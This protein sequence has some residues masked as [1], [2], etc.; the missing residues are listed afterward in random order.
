M[1]RGRGKSKEE[2]DDDILEIPR[3]TRQKRALALCFFD[4]A[5]GEYDQKLK[6][7]SRR[8]KVPTK[9]IALWVLGGYECIMDLE[10]PR[11][12]VGRPLPPKDLLTWEY[13]DE[14]AEDDAPGLWVPAHDVRDWMLTNIIQEGGR[15]HNPDHWHLEVA[16]VGVVWTNVENIKNGTRI[17]GTA[18]YLGGGGAIWPKARQNY[19][20]YEWFGEVPDFL[21]CLDANVAYSYDDAS[22]CA[23]LEH[24]M[25]HCGI[26]RDKWKAP[27]FDMMGNPQFGIL[28]H[29]VTEFVRVVERYGVGA[30]SAN[31]AEMVAVASR[32][33][34]VARADIIAACGLC[35]R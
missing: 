25:Y 12:A 17:A 19:Q 28:D 20:Y 34:T 3:F 15:I 18:E 4:A 5:R 13:P 30:A 22:F 16:K 24:E 14:E 29:D 33:P 2:E 26:K 11:A 9:I 7:A 6:L 27:K 31:V 1:A 8:T 10:T 35:N 23:L 32:E 21:I